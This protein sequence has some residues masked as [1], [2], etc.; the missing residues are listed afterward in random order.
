MNGKALGVLW[1]KPFRVDVTGAVKPGANSLEVKVTNL[2]VNRMIGDRQPDAPTQYTF[3]RPVFYKADSPLLPSGLLGPVRVLQVSAAAGG[4]ERRPEVSGAP[5]TIGVI[6][7]STRNPYFEDCRLGAQ[8]AADELGFTLSWEGPVEADAQ[9]QAQIVE[10]WTKD[11]LPVIA[12]SVES[13]TTLT[14]ALQ[15]R[16]RHWNPDPDLGLRWRRGGARLHGRAR[17]AG[18]DRARALV[19]GR[20]DPQRAGQLRRDH[21]DALRA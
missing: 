8:E 6:P 10:A 21:V 2:W 19:R 7:K 5:L 4:D 11:R 20:A 3:T 9:R 17:H 12:V 14:P 13:K 16:A 15:R 18:G 1:K